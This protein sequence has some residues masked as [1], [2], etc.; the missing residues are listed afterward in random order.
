MN[1]LTLGS[2]LRSARQAHGLGTRQLARLLGVA[3]SQISRWEADEVLPSAKFLAAL[4][5]QLELRSSDLFQLAGAPIPTDLANLPA[6]LRA[7]YE[8]PPE[9]IQEI[10]DHIAEVASKYRANPRD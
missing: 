6:M 5:E 8:L 10:Q 4:A 1:E 9:A 2:A 3:P 7:E